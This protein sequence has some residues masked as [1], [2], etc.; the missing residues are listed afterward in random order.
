MRRLAFLVLLT[1]ACSGS[2]SATT[3]SPDLSTATAVELQ[4]QSVMAACLESGCAGSPIYMR[5]TTD[6][7][8]FAAVMDLLGDEVRLI[9]TAEEE[10]LVGEDGRYADGGTVLS[11]EG[12]VQLLDNDVAGVDVFRWQGRFEG[13]GK[14]FLFRWDGTRWIATTQE[15]TGVVVT[16]AVP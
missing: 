1:T 12:A 9:S 16:T 15:E 14:S 5:D 3:T 10:A 6:P 8:L 7:E 2:P 11:V 4:A 13:L